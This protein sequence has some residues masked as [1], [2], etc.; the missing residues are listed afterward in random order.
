M[1]GFTP[2]AIISSKWRTAP[3]GSSDFAQALMAAV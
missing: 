3:A 2:A 1:S